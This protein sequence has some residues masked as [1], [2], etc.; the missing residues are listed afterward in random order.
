MRY[1]RLTEKDPKLVFDMHMID[2][3]KFNEEDGKEYVDLAGAVVVHRYREN[4]EGDSP[5]GKFSIRIN[6]LNNLLLGCVEYFLQAEPSF[7]GNNDEII[8]IDNKVREKFVFKKIRGDKRTLWDAYD[9][10]KIKF[11]IETLINILEG[12]GY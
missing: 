10:T 1:I 2:S 4:R 9:I 8:R 3:V 12:R 5:K 11:Q 6:R 7:E